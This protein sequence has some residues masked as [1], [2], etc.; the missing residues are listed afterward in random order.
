MAAL[1]SAPT[2]GRIPPNYEQGGYI[3]RMPHDPWGSNYV[4]Q[5]DGNNYMLKS[6]GADG[7]ESSD[8]IDGSQS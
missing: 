6:F 8:D 7:V 5:S 1:V 3:E 4:Y 2:N